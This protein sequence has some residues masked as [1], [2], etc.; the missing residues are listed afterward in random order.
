MRLLAWAGWWLLVAVLISGLP[1]LGLDLPR[2][3]QAW[4]GSGVVGD[5]LFSLV[6]LAFPLVGLLILRRQPR[7][8]V[9]W[10]LQAIGLVWALNLLAENYATY[11]M[12]LSPGSLPRPE[13]MAAFSQAGWVPA[14]GLMGTFLFLLYPDGHLPSPRWR[15]VAW[16]CG[17][18]IALGTLGVLLRPGT[19]A[20]SPI[21][22]TENPLA[23]TSGGPLLTVLM[24][25]VL[26]LLPIGII[27]CAIALVTRFR[28]SR[29]VE[30]LQLK[31]LA[32]AG[33]VVALLY[34]ATMVA[35][36]LG[37][38]TDVLDAATG[39]VT[40]LQLVSLVSFVLVPVSIGIAILLHGL[41]EVDV[42][43]NRALV[44][45]A[46]TATLAGVYLGSVLLLQLILSPVTSQSDLAVAGSTLA[47]AALF[48]PARRRIQRVV[49]R[50]FYRSRYDAARTLDDFT[51]RLRHQVD[52]DA[53]G[54]DLRSVVDTSVQPAH[55]SLW[56]RP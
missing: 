42:V 2:D 27:A 34:L 11:G 55:V 7:N 12:V 29:G 45:G 8:T 39:A 26:P 9:G 40:V 37:E 10:L 44:Y 20:G 23:W 19:M 51:D 48:R 41:Y 46:L 15:P 31:W 54:S 22:Q 28:R 3:S 52:L 17:A 53:V 6:V 32:L 49:D 47:V 38:V 18:T 56:V 33:A 13:V 21:P 25:V 30:R 16:V 5:L 4:G 36:L 14:I 1:L 43:I 35:V 24:V 50:R